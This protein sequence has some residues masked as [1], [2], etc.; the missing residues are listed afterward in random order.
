MAT[1]ARPPACGVMIAIGKPSLWNPLWNAHAERLVLLETT[2]HRLCAVLPKRSRVLASGDKVL[3]I[4]QG[5]KVRFP[6]GWSPFSRFPKLAMSAPPQ[7]DCTH[8]VRT[9]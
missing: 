2:R 8:T 3:R 9:D 6:S 1:C 5:L 7:A 4:P